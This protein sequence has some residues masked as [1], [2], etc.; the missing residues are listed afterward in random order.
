MLAQH[1]RPRHRVV[2]C[3]IHDGVREHVR[4][5][6]PRLEAV[7]DALTVERVDATGGVADEHPVRPGDVAHSTAHW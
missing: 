4:R 6:S 2:E 7:V 3:G 1:G 5:K